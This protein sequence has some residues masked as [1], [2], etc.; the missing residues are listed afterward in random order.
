MTYIEF[1]D[2]TSVVN[3][4]ACLTN[5][6][7]RVILVG[8]DMKP[9]QRHAE[10][11]GKVF[12]GRGHSVEFIC[13]SVNKTSLMNMVDVLSEIV[14]TYPECAVDL[15]G[16]ED[17]MLVAMGIVCERFKDKNIQLH[18]FNP[19][20]NTIYDCDNDGTTVK[21]DPLYLTVDENITIYGGEI[22]TDPDSI[23]STYE[24]DMNDEFVEDI[25]KMWQICRENN[26]KWNVQIGILATAEIIR[27][28][29]D[30]PLKLRANVKALTEFLEQRG[31]TYRVFRDEV[32]SPLCIA[33]LITYSYDDKRLEINYKNEQ[34]KRCLTNA[35]QV[36]ELKVFS[37]MRSLTDGGAPLYNV[38]TG[39]QIDW[40]GRN[41]SEGADTC[42]EVDVLAMKGVVPVFISCKNG[43]LSTD[44]LYKLKSV[45]ERFGGEYARKILICTAL[46]D[47]KE[48]AAAFRQRAEDMGIRIVDDFA[49]LSDREAQKMMKNFWH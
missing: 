37:L 48:F 5:P 16:G 13:K 49:Q 22:I 34:I 21:K 2:K 3:I 36:L 7:E 38:M 20:T 42:N 4:C 11:Y 44:E 41:R 47:E 1:F 30:H 35:G 6:P 39:V 43:Y 28:P 23:N 46:D 8:G 31:H 10:Y 17:L 45:A 12:S 32:L 24:W 40:D 18:R 26:H 25:D 14:S 15:T 29:Q 9:M 19:R 33:G 27:P